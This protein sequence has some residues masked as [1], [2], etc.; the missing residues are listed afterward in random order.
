MRRAGVSWLECVALVGILT[1]PYSAAARA[2]VIVAARDTHDDREVVRQIAD[3]PRV[4][5]FRREADAFRNRLLRWKQREFL[6]LFGPAIDPGAGDD[7]LLVGE[8]RTL[9][10][11]GLHSENPEDHQNHTAA[12]PVAVAGAGR[13]VVYFGHDGQSP[14]HVLFYLTTDKEFTKLDRVEKL[15]RRLAWGARGSRG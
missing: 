2:G 12:Y 8:P 9:L 15:D 6:A 1:S 14:V 4:L 3:D 13:L 10:L 7:A 5:A 11:S